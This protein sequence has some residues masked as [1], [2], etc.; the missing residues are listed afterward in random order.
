MIGVVLAPEPVVERV[1][2]H[3]PDTLWAL[4]RSERVVGGLALLMLNPGGVEAL[5]ANTLNVKDPP[6][7]FLVGPG[8][9]PAGIYIWGMAAPAIAFDGI[10]QIFVHL[11]SRRYESANIYSAPV[12]ADGLRFVEGWGFRP[13][14]GHPRNLHEYIRSANR[15]NH[16]GG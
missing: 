10:A 14:S 13:I 6:E 15:S 9:A 2:V 12:T 8:E 7:H 4:V 1:L 5:V 3:D 11:Q 16:L